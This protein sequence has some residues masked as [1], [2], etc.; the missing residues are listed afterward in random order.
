M[1]MSSVIQ[2]QLPMVEVTECHEPSRYHLVGYIWND[3]VTR[4]V[5]RVRQP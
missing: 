3:A 2:N 5:R 4:G 1:S